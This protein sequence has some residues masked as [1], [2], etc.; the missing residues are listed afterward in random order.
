VVTFNEARSP[1]RNVRFDTRSP[2]WATLTVIHEHQ[3]HLPNPF[4]VEEEDEFV[5]EEFQED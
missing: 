3:I 5:D 4:C 2:R 1:R